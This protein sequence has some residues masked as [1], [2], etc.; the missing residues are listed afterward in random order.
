M[1]PAPAQ[2]RENTENIQSTEQADVL[3]FLFSCFL[4]FLAAPASCVETTKTR[5]QRLLIQVALWWT[6]LFVWASSFLASF[7]ATFWQGCLVMHFLRVWSLAKR[8]KWYEWA[9]IQV[10]FHSQVHRQQRVEL[11]EQ[12]SQINLKSSSDAIWQ[13]FKLAPSPPRF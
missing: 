7:A 11:H 3:I 6:A 1:C 5:K 8:K 12:L 9:D 4:V 2:K 10:S 13:A